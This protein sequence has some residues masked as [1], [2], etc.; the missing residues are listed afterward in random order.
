MAV[1]MDGMMRVLFVYIGKYCALSEAHAESLFRLL[2]RIFEESILNTHQSKYTQF[3]IF[4]ICSLRPQFAKQFIGYLMNKILDARTPHITQQACFG[5]VASFLSRFRDTT[6]PLLRDSISVLVHWIH[7]YLDKKG[8]GQPDVDAHCSFYCA[9]QALFYIFCFKHT[10]LLEGG[11]STSFYRKLGIN[12]IALSPLN[13]LKVCLS[14]VV[15]E[16]ARISG[17]FSTDTTIRGVIERN[18]TVV[19][20]TKSATTGSANRLVSFFPFDPYVLPLS[21]RFLSDSYLQ[22]DQIEKTAATL[23][24]FEEDPS[25]DDDDDEPDTS[26]ILSSSLKA[27]SLSDDDQLLSST[28]RKSVV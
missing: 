21:R 22:W 11:E 28:D 19:L 17:L 23:L 10:Q 26:E 27:C 18:R 4:Y 8:S 20:P 13:P 2:L 6:A 24:P 25:D 3:L 9:C 1:R 5:Y 12:R 7:D 16:F 14:S 15:R